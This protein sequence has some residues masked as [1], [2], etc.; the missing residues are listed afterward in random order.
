V[1]AK[2]VPFFKPS[3]ELRDSVN[4]GGAKSPLIAKAVGTDPV[5]PHHPPAM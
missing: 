4:P 3:K 1:P 2:R 5:D